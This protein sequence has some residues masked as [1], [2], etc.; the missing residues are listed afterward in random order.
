VRLSPLRAEGTAVIPVPHGQMMTSVDYP[1]LPLM[2]DV[3]INLP[4]LKYHR[5]ANMS[6]AVKSTWSMA[7]LPVRMANHCN[8]LADALLDVHFARK[9]DVTLVDAL[10]PLEH[11]HAYGQMVPLG[12]V[13]AGT[14]SIAV[15]TVGALLMGFDPAWI[16]TIRLGGARGLGVADP[17]R[18][19]VEG[20]QVADVFQRRFAI[21]DMD[22]RDFPPLQLTW[23]TGRSTG[24]GCLAYLCTGLEAIAKDEALAGALG[25]IHV[26]VGIDP[27]IPDTI[28]GLC[29]VV[30]HCAVA[31]EA[32]RVLSNRKYLAQDLKRLITVPGCP[33]MALR[34]QAAPLLRQAIAGKPH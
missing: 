6:C 19:I 10:A 34:S 26:F 29:L 3:F 15:D 28:D 25:P 12:C 21:F 18:I 30:G 22:T 31:S 33:P 23:H 32:Y 14:D 4:V 20:D 5:Q 11:D 27:P 1:L 17:D 2:S 16:D 9:P 13:L 8:T 7:P 24:P